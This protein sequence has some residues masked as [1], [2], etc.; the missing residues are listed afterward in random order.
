MRRT[1]VWQINT[2]SLTHTL[3]VSYGQ[4]ASLAATLSLASGQVGAQTATIA[5]QGSHRRLTAT[6]N[7]V[8][9][10]TATLGA[11]P[12]RTVTYT[13]DGVS[14]TVAIRVRGRV[15]VTVRGAAPHRTLTVAAAGATGRVAYQLQ[16][17]R[18]GRWGAVAKTRLTDGGGHA[19]VLLP[20]ALAST[21]ANRLRVVINTQPAWS[22]INVK[23]DA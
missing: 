7:A 16:E 1:Y 6:T 21:P 9:S 4:T 23:E 18:R 2:A 5:Q 3:T 13:I 14:H 22:F 17:Y 11:G 19:A 12:S 15:T 10:F 20:A 8:G